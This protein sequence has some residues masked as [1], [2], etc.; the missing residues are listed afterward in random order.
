MA[1]YSFDPKE[2][3]VIVGPYIIRGFSDSQV[4]L[5]RTNPAW[6]LVVGADGEATRVKSND[7]SGTVTI[8]LQ[9]SSP[10][11]DELTTLALADELSN[12]GL[13]PLFVKDNLGTTLCSAETAYIE[14][15][16]DAAFAKTAQTREWVIRADDLHMF[17]G[18]NNVS[19]PPGP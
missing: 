7:R 17:I 8:S 2:L 13:F 19:V 10:S 9:Q 15:F 5:A 12:T 4:T 14:K 11:N 3:S 16:P 6:E 1:L 18:G